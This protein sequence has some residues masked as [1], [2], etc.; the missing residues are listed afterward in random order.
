MAGLTV[1]TSWDDG[2]ETDLRLAER[3]AAHGLKGTFYVAFNDP[4]PAEIGDAGIRE[5]HRMG[6]EVGSHT[7][8]HRLLSPLPAETV[9]HEFAESRRRLENII[10]APVRSLSYPQ[11][12]YTRAAVAAL[13]ETG[14][15]LGR[16]TVAFHTGGA[17]DPALMPISLEFFRYSRAAIARHAA[18]DANFSGL[19]AWARAGLETDPE[20]LGRRL[21]DRAAERGGVFHVTARSWEID[22]EG[23]WEP[24]E[25]LFRH[26]AGRTGVRYVTNSEAARPA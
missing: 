15:T 16:T 1:T 21:F 19:A 22:R 17:F 8:T 24:L 10:G 3:L 9:R 5:L 20:T 2:H 25:R 6:M 18:R 4:R 12:A 7:L 23:L 13:R 11:G 26:V 14:Y